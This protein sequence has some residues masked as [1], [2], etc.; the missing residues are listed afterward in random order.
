[1]IALGYDVTDSIPRLVQEM[2]Q[3]IS[4]YK[5]ALLIILKPIL[6]LQ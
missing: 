6:V 3:C 2:N 4:L 5:K 1:M